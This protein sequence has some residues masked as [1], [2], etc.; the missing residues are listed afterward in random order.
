MLLCSLFCFISERCGCEIRLECP[1]ADES[2]RGPR[3]L[4]PR[5]WLTKPFD[6]QFPHCSLTGCLAASASV[7]MTFVM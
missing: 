3:E 6:D 7:V 2:Q 5:E 4:G 1:A